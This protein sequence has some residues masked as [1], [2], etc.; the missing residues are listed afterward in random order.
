MTSELVAL[1]LLGVKITCDTTVTCCGIDK[2]I[3]HSLVFMT[4]ITGR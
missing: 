2:G 1:T 3:G 4:A